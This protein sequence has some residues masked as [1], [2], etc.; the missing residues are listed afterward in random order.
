MNFA[1]LS[2]AGLVGALAATTALV[3]TLYLLRR[4]PRTQVVSNI[5]FWR[6]AAE[7]SRPRSLLAT[8]I[9]WLAMLLSLLVGLLLVVELADPRTGSGFSGTT[10]IVLDADRTMAARDEH[11]RRRLDEALALVREIVQSDTVTGR[12][13]II[14]AGV[15]NEVLV[16]L[17]HRSADADRGLRSTETDDGTADLDGAVSIAR[18]IVT[19][20]QATGRVVVLSDREDF[21]RATVR[22]VP[23]TLVPIGN[24][25]ETIAITSLDARRDPNA[26]GEYYARCE[27]RSYSAHAARVHLVLRD[28]DVT[29]SEETITLQPGEVHTHRAHG[30]SSAQA[31]LTARLEDIEIAGGRDAL[32][33]DD[34]TYAAI[35][36]VV[37]THVL[38]V[39]SGNRYLQ[40]ALAANPS[41]QLETIAPD[42]LDARRSTLDHYH[43]IVLD[44]IAPTPPLAHP[45]QLYFGGSD[46]RV[47][48]AGPELR[49]PRVTA[50]A[51]DHRILAGLRFDQVGLS[52]AHAILPEADDRVLVRSGRNA[53]AIARDRDGARTV[54]LGFDTDGTD[55]VQ[56]VAFP[57]FVHS[58]LVWLDH[59]ERAFHS[60]Q[61]PGDP[62]RAA[63]SPGLVLD[64][65]GE[66]RAVQGALYD[67]TRAGIYHTADRAIAVSSADQAG[68]LVAAEGSR[69]LHHDTHR[70]KTPI[71][72]I[73]AAALVALMAIEWFVT[74]R[75]TFE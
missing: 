13:A 18:A 26:L 29:V 41:V 14:R 58:T 40:N 59:R 25:A 43:V 63:G 12:V 23:V 33:T 67:T 9:P 34:V 57:L 6:R 4:T 65:S 44:R 60:W 21:A 7:R 50:F 68:S 15:R 2:T 56:R 24:A 69:D 66:G 39:T 11:G 52:R 62:I 16:P 72:L 22:S 35:A 45:A 5:E 38:L 51:T 17:T 54:A 27:V 28:R 74:Q 75:G 53:L 70:G 48:R 20:S 42:G 32:A 10:V 8:R 64:P 30:F 1:A 36:P 71:A 37:A 46:G 61:S 49:D 47:V 55:L 19:R 73:L 3:V 31:E